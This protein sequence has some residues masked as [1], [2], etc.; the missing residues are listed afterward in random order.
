[1]PRASERNFGK[2]EGTTNLKA[3]AEYLVSEQSIDKY[4]GVESL[5]ELKKRTDLFWQ[6]IQELPQNTILIVGHGAFYRSLNRSINGLSIN[7]K[8][9]PLNNCELTKLV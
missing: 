2:L 9:P 1:M 8:V 3:S 5:Q 7:I 4:S 6:D